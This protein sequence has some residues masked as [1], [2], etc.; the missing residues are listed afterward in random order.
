MLKDMLSA[1]TAQSL[2][3]KCKFAQICEQLDEETRSALLRAMAV[4]SVSGKQITRALRESGH[5]IGHTS[6]QKARLCISG[7]ELDCHNCLDGVQ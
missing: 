2:S 6:I 1:L 7:K 4:P 3:P 5:V